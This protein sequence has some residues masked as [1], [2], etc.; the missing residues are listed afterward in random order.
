MRIVL[1]NHCHPETPHV[2]ATRMREFAIALAAQGH[3]IVLLTESLDAASATPA[4]ATVRQELAQHDFSQLY[5][6]ACKPVG[7]PLLKRL[8]EGRLSWW[9]R[10][11]VIFW[12][13]LVRDGL[14]T[15]W[16]DG[17]APYL[18][19]LA[20]EFEPDVTLGSFGNT[21]CWNIARDIARRA[22]CPWVA[23]IKDHWRY[24]IPGLFRDRLAARF[25]DAA[26]MTALSYAHVDE[27]A[28]WF[29]MTKTAVYSGFRREVL[30]EKTPPQGTEFTISLTG[31]IY[32]GENLSQLVSAV[33][34]WLEGMTREETSHVRFVYAGTDQSAV[35]AATSSLDRLCRVDI[36][37]FIPL[38]ELHAL[39]RSCDVNMYVKSERCFHHKVLEL[40]A[41]GR[42]ILCFPADIPEAV[43]IIEDTAGIMYSCD[44]Q[45]EIVAALESLWKRPHYRT[46]I[47]QLQAYT[48]DAQAKRLATVLEQV[49]AE[50]RS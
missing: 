20:E 15:N 32:D 42:P 22:G 46:D 6:L 37:G 26:A 17:C 10:Q 48:W 31:A 16:R 47:L 14:F 1:V 11:I 44:H 9:L 33:A 35:A 30:A 18:P 21:D 41:A 2:C 28:A 34:D 4:P 3:R 23:D 8:R 50:G 39:H 38:S 13:Y 40:A 36:N 19:V 24:F 12:G 25:K 43:T 45:D 7:R 49:V 27:A 5:V 29:R